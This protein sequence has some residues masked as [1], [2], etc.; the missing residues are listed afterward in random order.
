MK[1]NYEECFGLIL[2]NLKKMILILARIR[3]KIYLLI[4][5]DM[6]STN[7]PLI[8][9]LRV[10][11]SV[12]LYT[13]RHRSLPPKAETKLICDPV[14]DMNEESHHH[15][16]RHENSCLVQDILECM[17]AKELDVEERT[18]KERT[19]LVQKFVGR[20]DMH[21]YKHFHQASGQRKVIFVILPCGEGLT[22]LTY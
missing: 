14:T 18:E 3:W 8:W 17:D 2:L 9:K 22:Q 20:V 6:P 10:C 12:P 7:P 5:S 13:F 16:E 4:R 11:N 1:N 19:K 15:V 21:G